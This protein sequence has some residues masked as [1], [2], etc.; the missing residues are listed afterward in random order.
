MSQETAEVQNPDTETKEQGTTTEVVIKTPQKY[1]FPLRDQQDYK[2]KVT[3]KVVVVEG[4]TPSLFKSLESLDTSSI[5]DRFTGLF[6][7]DEETPTKEE[8]KEGQDALEGVNGTTQSYENVEAQKTYGDVVTLYLP[9]SFAIRDAV[10]YD[11]VNLGFIG[12]AVEAVGQAGGSIA[13]GVGAAAKGGVESFIDAFR[14]GAGADAASVAI[15]KVAGMGGAGVGGAVQSL[16]RT[17]VNP[18]TRSIFQS[19]PMREFPFTFRLIASSPQEAEEI[20][21]IVKTFRRE[22]YPGTISAPLPGDLG[23][24]IP[25][26]YRMPNLFEIKMTYDNKPIYTGIQ[27]AYLRDVTVSY[28]AN[29]MAFHNVKGKVAPVEVEVTLSFIESRTMT[30]EM[31]EEGF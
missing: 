11:N 28:N 18:N 12:G 19:V 15:T 23:V 25:I 20:K 4:I 24:S 9:P 6:S 3:F 16:T 22:L 13:Q 1:R 27:D 17:T 7:S 5:L 30:R 10:T 21:K 31:V 14:G 26:G 2:G 29:G 8:A